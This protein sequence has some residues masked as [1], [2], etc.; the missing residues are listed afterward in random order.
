[1]FPGLLGMMQCIVRLKFMFL[2]AMK[3]LMRTRHLWEMRQDIKFRQFVLRFRHQ[4]CTETC[5]AQ[6]MRHMHKALV[7]MVLA[8]GK[9]VGT[10]SWSVGAYPFGKP[11]KPWKLPNS[12]QDTIFV[13]I[14]LTCSS[15][16]LHIWSDSIRNICA[17]QKSSKYVS[18]MILNDSNPLCLQ[19]TLCNGIL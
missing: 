18:W 1:M 5:L 12:A 13:A 8:L 10:R 2:F 6:H 15:L 19:T 16:T 4:N 7:R 9:V 17:R 14:I 3:I 11:R